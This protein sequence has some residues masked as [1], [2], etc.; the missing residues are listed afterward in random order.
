MLA[1][2]SKKKSQD[3]V[4]RSQ[5]R[6]NQA[7]ECDDRG[8][9]TRT[10]LTPTVGSE[11]GEGLLKG[12]LLALVLQ[13]FCSST[14]GPGDGPAGAPSRGGTPPLIPLKGAT[15]HHVLN[16]GSTLGWGDICLLWESYVGVMQRRD[17]A[18]LQGV[19]V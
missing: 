15:G 5:Q 17:K 13:R 6:L 1:F 4:E 3:K 10:M 12:G 18:L 19:V 7:F 9:L 2:F 16:Q 11:A 14:E 8:M